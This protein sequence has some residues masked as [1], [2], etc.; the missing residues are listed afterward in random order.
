MANLT[1]SQIYSYYL[2]EKESSSLSPL[3]TE[4][5][6]LASELIKEMKEKLK[7]AEEVG[8]EDLMIKYEQS[9]RTLKM[10]LKDLFLLRMKK[11]VNLAVLLAETGEE[12]DLINLLP[13]E[14]KF[15][16]SL[17]NDIKEYREVIE[18]I[19]KGEYEEKVSKYKIVVLKENILEFVW[20][21]ENV[22][23]PFNKGDIAVLEESLAKYLVEQ[24][25]AEYLL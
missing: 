11:I 5:P 6:K 24:G 10:Y 13:I 12:L 2:K 20:E 7:E 18:S 25:K 1:L 22:Y 4:F 19:L 17:V 14:K 3:P 8:D 21:D 23:G 15:L 9:L 16:K